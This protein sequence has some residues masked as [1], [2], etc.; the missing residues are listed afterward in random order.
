MDSLG[1]F[2]EAEA[3]FQRAQRLDPLSLYTNLTAG[4]PYFYSRQFDK[5]AAHFKKVLEMDSTFWL[6]QTYEGEGKYDEAIAEYQT[7]LRMRGGDVTRAVELGYAFA[8]AGRQ[9]EARQMLAELERASKKRYVPPCSFI[10][11]HTGLGEKYQALAWLEKGLQERDNT[12]AFIKVDHRLDPLRSDPRF[13]E[14][15]K[16]TGLPQ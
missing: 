4:T 2:D 9:A 12:I 3:E 11:I 1:K 8:I 16:D 15:I 5:A 10:I 7:V 14:L 6:A 13:A